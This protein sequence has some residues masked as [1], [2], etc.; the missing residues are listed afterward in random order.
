MISYQHLVLVLAVMLILFGGKRLPE[1]ASS[2]GKSLKEFKKGS[3][4]GTDESGSAGSPTVAAVA[5]ATCVSCRM[6]LQAEGTHC[7]RC[8]TA[9]SQGSAP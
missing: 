7:P 9:I 1:L 6:P 4:G 3:E 2:L 8:G 5:S